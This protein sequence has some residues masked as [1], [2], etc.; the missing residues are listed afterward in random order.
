MILPPP[1]ALALATALASSAPIP[2]EGGRA[3]FII[4]PEQFRRHVIALEP[5]QFVQATVHQL[6]ID[7]VLRLLGP[8]GVVLEE[9]FDSSEGPVGREPASLQA[10]VGGLYTVEVFAPADVAGPGR[11]ELESQP[12]RQ[13]DARDRRRREAERLMEVGGRFMGPRAAGRRRNRPGQEQCDEAHRA[14]E[15]V[16]PLW[17]EL[18]EPWWEAEALTC[19]ALVQTWLSEEQSIDN[20]IRALDLW[21]AAGDDDDYKFIEAVLY[22]GRAMDRWSRLRDAAQMMEFGLLLAR[23]RDEVLTSHFLIQLAGVY[24]QLG[25]STRAIEL[26]EEGLAIVRAL[27]HKPRTAVVL[28]NLARAHY[29][30]GSL[31]KANDL[32]VEAL[33]L[34]REIGEELG[35]M[36][37]LATLAEISLGLGDPDLALSYVDETIKTGTP[38]GTVAAL[39][40]TMGVASVLRGLGKPAEARARLLRA[41]EVTN[42]SNDPRSTMR[43]QLALAGLCLDDHDAAAAR[44]LVDRILAMEGTIGD[45]FVRAEA[46]DLRARLSLAAN[47]LPLAEEASAQS[48]AIRR[49]VGDRVGEATSLFRSAQIARASQDLER[50]RVLLQEARGIVA[51]Q[52]TDLLIPQLRATWT[53]T[54]REIEEAYVSVLTAL[55][56]RDPERGFDVLAFE[57]SD[58]ASARSL[59]DTLAD[60]REPVTGSAADRERAARENLVDAL[61]RQM[62][63]RA[64]SAPAAER[65]ALER[66]VRDLS[67]EHDRLWA[68]ARASDP[69]RRE[70]PVPLVLADIQSRVLDDETTLLEFFLGAERGHAWAV[71]RGGLH[72]YALP[73]RARVDAAVE[74]VKAALARPPGPSSGPD[75][76]SAALRAL[77]ELVLPRER[78]VLRG[79]RLLIVADGSLHHVPFAALPDASGR[80][81]IEQF[82]IASLPSA[83]VAAQLRRE[84][85]ERPPAPRAIAVL[86]DPVYDSADPRLHG[87]HGTILADATLKQATREF[88]FKDGRLPRLPFTRREALSLAA[89]APASSTVQLDF[90]AN[91]DAALSSELGSYRY[92]HFATHG[93]LND[94]RPELSGL[95]LSLVDREGR[96]RRGLLTAPA[97]SALRLQAELVVLSSCRSAAGRE[98]KGEGLVGL[99]R[100]FMHAGA[101]RVV[102]SLWPVDDLAS[103]AFMTRM[104]GGLLGP[105]KLTPAAALRAAQL[106]MLRHRR[107]RAPYYWAAFQ[108]QGEWR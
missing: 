94:A 93:L 40:P 85:A 44:P 108:L 16:L 43:A 70:S 80:P 53:G 1:A 24:G 13:P 100:A 87:V 51:V 89:L 50:A 82:E 61:E 9:R 29:R 73:S 52:R 7:V 79:T 25:D 84:L 26:G 58:A 62:R 76:A 64:A 38:F 103:S 54:V 18:G 69:V 32:A 63:S 10:T 33:A 5:G 2:L 47:D 60:Q 59:L 45:P 19:L 68:E 77:A 90:A 36:A 12:P 71:T 37:T 99:T 55:D 3:T 107:W 49:A 4:G 91:V 14:Y 42:P 83:S 95:V 102:A 74:A 67:A 104:Y 15:A 98:V 27:E 28:T 106:E 20:F 88:G 96:P 46:L 22:T 23:D 57:G 31:Q 72:A 48:L 78:S 41:I 101:P 65:L 75:R 35:L 56:A 97:V 11:Y 92:V 17:Q 6:D 66:E 39:L 81:L 30:R 21:Q 86:A 8:D 34:R 105:R